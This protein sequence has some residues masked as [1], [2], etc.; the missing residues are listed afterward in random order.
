[1]KVTRIM[2]LLIL[3]AC[4]LCT[5]GLSQMTKLRLSVSSPEYALNFFDRINYLDDELSYKANVDASTIAPAKL[6]SWD[7]VLRMVEHPDRVKK[8]F[9]VEWDEIDYLV[10]NNIFAFSS[11]YFS[12]GSKWYTMIW[13]FRKDNRGKN[14]YYSS[15]HIRKMLMD[16]AQEDVRKAMLTRL[17]ELLKSED[18]EGIWYQQ[19]ADYLRNLSTRDPNYERFSKATYR[20][21][22]K[23]KLQE[24]ID[25]INNTNYDL[26][27]L[28]VYMGHWEIVEVKNGKLVYYYPDQVTGVCY[29]LGREASFKLKG[30]VQQLRDQM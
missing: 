28:P 11:L 20:S 15:Y 30:Y 25:T 14:L 13:N 12:P 5:L 2:I 18:M 21:S 24:V 22:V 3:L 26:K 19:K 10:R 4:A 8:D 23:A 29:R 9:Y 6:M 7:E 17:V 16:T 27:A 1:M